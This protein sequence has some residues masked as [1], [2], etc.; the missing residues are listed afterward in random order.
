MRS[1]GVG[2]KPVRWHRGTVPCDLSITY[3]RVQLQAEDHQGSRVPTKSEKAARKNS[4]QSPRKSTARP[5]PW[6]QAS[7]LQD[8]KKINLSF[9]AT[10]VVALCYGRPRNQ[11]CPVSSSRNI[12][13]NAF[14]SIH[15][16]TSRFKSTSQPKDKLSKSCSLHDTSHLSFPKEKLW[17][18]DVGPTSEILKTFKNDPTALW[19]HGS[20]RFK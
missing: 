5:T 11:T 14:T 2:P 7:G 1:L 12:Q 16:L 13:R 4:T 6:F 8:Y 17:P 15:L 3:W 18:D 19:L 20:Q 9:Q 10:Q